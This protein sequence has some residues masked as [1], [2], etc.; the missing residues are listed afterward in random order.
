MMRSPP[1]DVADSD[2]G[3]LLEGVIADAITTVWGTMPPDRLRTD[4]GTPT[5]SMRAIRSLDL[6]RRRDRYLHDR[7]EDQVTWYRGKSVDNANLARLWFR[8]GFA[9]RI[10]ALIAALAYLV[11]PGALELTQVFVAFA[12]AIT[13]WM[14]LGRYE[15]LSQSYQ[16][17]AQELTRIRDLVAAADSERALAAAVVEAEGSISREHKMWTAKRL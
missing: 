3:A 16:I 15:E 11:H 13:A 2:A 12:A 4:S 6:G 9:F 14:E 5:E 7:L 17:A 1:Y 10:F 8:I